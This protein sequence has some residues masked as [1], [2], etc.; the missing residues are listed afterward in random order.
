MIPVK[1]SG[2]FNTDLSPSEK[3]ALLHSGILPVNDVYLPLFE[4]LASIDLVYGGRG[5]GKSES[6]ADY[7]IEESRT[8]EYFKCY[9]GRKVFENVR[10]SCF[11]TLVYAIKK[12]GLQ[13]EFHFSEANTSTMIIVNNN[14]GGKFIPFGSDKAD[15]LKSIKDPTHIWGEEFDQFTFPDFKELFPTL[16]TIRGKNKFIGSLN[17]HCVFTDQWIIKVF[18]PEL[19]TGDDLTEFDILEGVEVNKIFANYTDN[20]FIDQDDYR[21]RLRL[22]SGGNQFIFDG[23][24]NGAWGVEPNDNPWL[25]AF[26][27]EKHGIR[28]IPYLPSFPVY[29]FID[30]NN[31]PLECTLWQMSPDFGTK[32]SFLHCIDEYSGKFKIEELCARIA[33]DYPASIL[34]LGGDRSGQNEDVG[35]NQTI[36]QIMAAL[37]RINKKNVLLNNYNLEHA[38]SR[39]LCNAM[40]ANYPNIYISSKC[41]NLIRQC[42]IA[43]IDIDS[44]KPSHLL[45]DREK[46]KLD[47]FDSMRYMFQTLFNEWAKKVYFKVLSR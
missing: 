33:S 21:N 17:T 43:R 39:L 14:T 8:E 22:A 26:D 30:I 3:L 46:F 44:N 15:K 6:I 12:R 11:D 24:A 25:Y 20:Y 42:Q 16:R 32:N 9:Y 10:G 41:K 29:I 37:L 40:F 35:R 18:F 38:D 2:W 28:D 27:L 5:G 13:R 47:A 4:S 36:Y 34:Y 1:A 23:I 19:Y 7:L 31:E 45:K